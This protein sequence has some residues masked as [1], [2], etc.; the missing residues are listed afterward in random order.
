MFSDKQW[1]EI[2]PLLPT[3]KL[4]P[5]GGRPRLSKR[6]VFEGILYVFKHRIAWKK[7]P[8]VYG[9]GTALNDY[10]REWVQRGVFHRLQDKDIS[11][12]FNLD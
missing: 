11:L 8:K 3:Y 12:P 2:A 6:K 1:A 10:F 7:V 9:S 5:S 4:S